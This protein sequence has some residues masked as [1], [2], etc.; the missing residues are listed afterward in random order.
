MRHLN[1]DG[2]GFVVVERLG[3]GSQGFR[4]G[5]FGV[6]TATVGGG[7]NGA[8][9]GVFIGTHANIDGGGE[10]KIESAGGAGKC[11]LA[12]VG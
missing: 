6:G 8:V 4:L 12:R 3:G 11:S 2:D 7:N 9:G 1:I 10:R 5:G